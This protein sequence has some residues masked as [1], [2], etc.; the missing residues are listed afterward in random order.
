[1]YLRNMFKYGHRKGEKQIP[2][3]AC[4]ILKEKFGHN[5]INKYLWKLNKNWH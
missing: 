5:C 4:S 1:M 2:L 3:L